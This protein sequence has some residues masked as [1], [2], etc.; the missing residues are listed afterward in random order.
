MNKKIKLFTL[1]IVF[2][3]GV[4]S[5]GYYAIAADEDY[6]EKY[7]NHAETVNI[8]VTGESMTDAIDDD[9]ELGG[10]FHYIDEVF[11]SQLCFDGAM[12]NCLQERGDT[13]QYTNNGGTSWSDVGNVSAT[14]GGWTADGTNFKIYPTNNAS[15]Y[16]YPVIIGTTATAT[17][18]DAD[19]TLYVSGGLVATGDVHFY[20]GAF[21]FNDNSVADLDFRAESNGDANCFMIDGSADK[22]GMGVADPGAKLE[23]LSTTAQLWL[24]YDGSNAVTYTVSSGGDLTV[25][26]SGGDMTIT[27]TLSVG[28]TTIGASDL[29][30]DTDT[31]YVDAD[32]DFIGIGVADPDA[33]LE[34]MHTS[35]P[36]KLSYDGS[37]SCSFAVGA[38]GDGTY[39]CS[40][41]DI[42]FVNENL[43]TTGTFGAA[44]TTLS[45][46]LTVAT[47]DFFVDNSANVVFIGT[48][49]GISG[50]DSRLQVLE[51][52]SIN[53][54]TSPYD[55]L[56]DFIDSSDDAVMNMYENNT[57][58]LRL[59]G[60]TGGDS[61]ID[62]DGFFYDGSTDRVG[63]ST[64]TPVET[65]DIADGFQ[66]FD[67]TSPYD[68]LMKGYDSDDDGI[69]DLYANQT[70]T[71]Q[72]HGNDDSYI[73]SGN[74]GIGTTSPDCGLTVGDTVP[75]TSCSGDDDV[76]VT[77]TLEVDGA[78]DFD[79]A[80]NIA[81]ATVL[82]GTLGVS[83]EITGL[84]GATAITAT[85]TLTAATHA[86]HTLYIDPADAAW[87]TIT[88]PAATEGLY[89][90]FVVAG[91]FT[92]DVAVDSAEGD[93]IEGSLIVAGAVVDCAAVD[94]VNFIADGENLGDFFELYSDGTNWFIGA[95]GALTASKMTC[96]D[97]S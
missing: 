80:I 50:V 64:T 55:K 30:I 11:E 74:L 88:L 29:T 57:I 25:V 59:T 23:I 31:L 84:R 32:G 36:L 58:T 45:D 92:V 75:T 12:Q 61:Y 68:V 51:G 96:T 78:V 13:I 28:T 39:T 83:G 41:G 82:A 3:L 77:G 9:Q 49:T 26:P 44:A 90:R 85:T 27:S 63:L 62:T 67:S 87:A 73:T 33:G 72:L 70:V 40:G 71:I 34:V 76:M 4:F 53:D 22:V 17:P 79:G 89:L 91:T 46:D 94:Q 47:P 56:F 93:N 54:A 16:Q 97:P 18:A 2:L 24:S 38:S 69:F 66:V 95:S 42:T 35:A 15:G 81:G 7:I 14:S 1:V 10:I 21:T 5:V 48:T 37:Y 19:T 6:G 52:I 86:G 8:Y 43:V 65:L 20:G 60:A